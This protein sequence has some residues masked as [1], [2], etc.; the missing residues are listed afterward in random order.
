MA[1]KVVLISDM[2]APE[3]VA[4]GR[5]ELAFTQVSEILDTPGAHLL[6]PLPGELQSY[7]SFSVATSDR[8]SAP[9]LAAQFVKALSLPAA[10]AHM[11]ARGLI[12]R[13]A[14]ELTPPAITR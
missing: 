6:G 8:T 7:S 12:P 13:P 4:Q 2:T 1:P 9:A 11:R 10:Q 3:A 14:S 5:A